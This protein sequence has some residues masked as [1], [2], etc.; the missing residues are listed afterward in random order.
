MEDF[1][2]D[3]DASTGL[4]DINPQPDFDLSIDFDGFIFMLFLQKYHLYKTD[5]TFIRN[6]V[7]GGY[8]Q[9]GFISDRCR[10]QNLDQYIV[11]IKKE[12]DRVASGDSVNM[13]LDDDYNRIFT[14][15][16]D[17]SV[18]F[19]G[20][21]KVLLLPNDQT[22]YTRYDVNID[23]LPEKPF[24]SLVQFCDYFNPQQYALGRATQVMNKV[25]E[26]K[27]PSL[28]KA[29]TIIWDDKDP[30][31]IIENIPNTAHILYQQK[32]VTDCFMTP[33]ITN[34]SIKP[35]I[36]NYN[37]IHERMKKVIENYQRFIW[38]LQHG[39]YKVDESISVR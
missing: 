15:L 38:E 31:H 36:D 29:N 33:E 23:I 30:N 5:K 14:S 12:H 28:I 25:S 11:K 3:I 6:I 34:S 37:R 32:V 22:T 13:F 39:K 26:H 7:D 19:L 21:E 27:S 20:E 10:M 9:T 2:E 35:I 4:I 1:Y 24:T 18:R 8:V 17:V 16:S